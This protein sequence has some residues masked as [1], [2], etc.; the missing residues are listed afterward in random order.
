[1]DSN[2]QLTLPGHTPSPLSVGALQVPASLLRPPPLFLR[3]A[4]AAVCTPTLERGYPRTP[5]CARCRNHGVVSALK[6][7]KRFCRWRDCVC[8]KC[9]LIAERQR[10]MAAQ[11]ALRRQQAQE[12]SEAR[13]LG[14]MYPGTGPSETEMAL[15]NPRHSSG[16]MNSDVFGNEERNGEE[17]KLNKYNIYNGFLGRPL[18]A[19]HAQCLTSPTG[20]NDTVF[21]R[22]KNHG[23]FNKASGNQSPGFDQMS[24]HTLSP[25]SMSSS[26]LESGSESEKPKDYSLVDLKGP[27]TTSKD[28]DPI[29]VLIKIFPHLKRDT[30]ESVLRTCMGDIV[31]AI[32]LV[33]TS[34]ENKNSN[35]LVIPVS[36]TTATSRPTTICL[37]GSPVGTLNAKSAF[38]PLQTTSAN[39][40]V[41]ESAYGLNS[42][43]GINPLRLAYSTSGALP[44]F[45]S[46][47]LTPGLLPGLPLRPTVDYPFPGMI[48]DFPYVQSKDSFSNTG[49]FSRLSNDK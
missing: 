31:K 22:D 48:R 24:D 28:R 38:S 1:M 5:K 32:E 29:E 34:K 25:R 27:A 9:T 37:A 7:H 49:L 3:A 44:S 47:Y 6:G 43:F 21:A 12:E 36:E 14:L 13:E 10:V 35:D 30:L 16:S 40:M 26:D 41:S 8:A 17:E 2:R 19:H 45:I 11:V 46:P 33:L 18:F 39:T 4:A 20:K 15:T 23:E 42:R